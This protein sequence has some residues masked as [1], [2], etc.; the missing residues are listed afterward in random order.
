MHTHHGFIGDDLRNP[1]MRTVPLVL[2][3]SVVSATAK[4]SDLT[5]SITGSGYGFVN[6][7]FMYHHRIS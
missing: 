1:G 3:I 2:A 4:L 7:V 6:T 5:N